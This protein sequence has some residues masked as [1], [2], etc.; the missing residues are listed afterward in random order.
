ME[1]KIVY[2]HLIN[3]IKKMLKYLI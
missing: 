1:V 2:K 3:S